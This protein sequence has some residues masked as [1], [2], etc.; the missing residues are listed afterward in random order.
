M[1]VKAVAFKEVLQTIALAWLS[2]SR[3]NKKCPLR[4]RLSLL[5]YK[6]VSIKI[7]GFPLP[8][9]EKFIMKK[10]KLLSA[11]VFMFCCVACGQ[12]EHNVQAMPAIFVASTPCTAG[13]RP[14]PGMRLTGKCEL[15]KWKLQIFGMAGSN[16]TRTYILDCDYGIAKQGTR[17]LVNGGTHLH[18]EGKWAI[19]TGMP[20]N[21]TAVIFCLDPGK[22]KESVYLLHLSDELL[23]LID[24]DRQLM[25]GTA[26]WSYTL[27]KLP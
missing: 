6:R 13:T 4:L 27:N 3:R 8:C 11:A 25:T 17:G 26:A 9:N 1:K 19:Q 12:T 20:G 7:Y 16:S 14:L 21:P 5:L 22:P 18:R 2:I 15:I 24:S 10:A 23:H